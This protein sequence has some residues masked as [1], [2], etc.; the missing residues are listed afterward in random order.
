MEIDRSG[1][2][3]ECKAVC[4]VFGDRANMS[5]HRPSSRPGDSKMVLGYN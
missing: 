2:V 5:S 4:V 1:H 3:D